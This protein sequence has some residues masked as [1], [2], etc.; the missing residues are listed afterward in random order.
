MDDGG[1]TTNETPMFLCFNLKITFICVYWW[2]KEST[3]WLVDTRDSWGIKQFQNRGSFVPPFF[4]GIDLPHQ[5]VVDTYNHMQWSDYSHALISMNIF[6]ASSFINLNNF[7]HGWRN[8]EDWK[9][10]PQNSN[11]LLNINVEIVIHT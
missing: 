10:K 1:A 2:D 5:R 9:A 7:A 8:V 3:L 11:Y 4:P 6:C